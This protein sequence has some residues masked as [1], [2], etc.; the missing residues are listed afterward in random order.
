MNT[1][2]KHVYFVI[3]SFMNLWDSSYGNH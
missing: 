3:Q 1:H 2:F